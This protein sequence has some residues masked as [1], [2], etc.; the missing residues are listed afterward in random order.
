METEPVG[1]GR[2]N[3]LTR[4]ELTYA[5][6][7]REYAEGATADEVWRAIVDCMVIAQIH[8]CPYNG[9]KMTRVGPGAEGEGSV[10]AHPYCV[11]NYCPYTPDICQMDGRCR[12]PRNP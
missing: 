7:A 6:G 9:P 1:R 3:P 5:D 4:I 11:Y 10:Y 8:N 2:R 12:H